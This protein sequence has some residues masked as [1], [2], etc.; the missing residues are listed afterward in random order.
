[1]DTK[2]P[3]PVIIFTDRIDYEAAKKTVLDLTPQLAAAPT[4]EVFLDIIQPHILAIVE[5]YLHLLDDEHYRPGELA[6]LLYLIVECVNT[7]IPAHLPYEAIAEDVQ[8]YFVPQ[9]PRSKAN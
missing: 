1:M 5:K 6:G 4:I 8:I 3:V 9:S 7:V 2:D